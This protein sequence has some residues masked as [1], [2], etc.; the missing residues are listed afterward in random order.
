MTSSGQKHDREIARAEKRAAKA[1]K[2]RE[3]QPLSPEA[4]HEAARAAL[5]RLTAHRLE[6]RS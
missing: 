6:R 1:A 4:R 2:K 5:R 3:R